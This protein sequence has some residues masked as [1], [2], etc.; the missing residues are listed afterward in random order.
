[1]TIETPLNSGN[2]TTLPHGWEPLREVARSMALELFNAAPWGV[3]G[4]P[5]KERQIEAHSLLL[6]D[7]TRPASRDTWTRWLAEKVGL[8][9]DA[10]AP[11]WSRHVC[12]DGSAYWFL[13]GAGF[14]THEFRDPAIAKIVDPAAA[15]CAA[16]LAVW[17]APVSG[18]EGAS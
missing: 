14:R 15:L 1:M 11:R 10:T 9:V 2:L 4:G 8:A 7:L 18:K 13:E 6:A 5:Q 16:L 17:S 12:T 3:W